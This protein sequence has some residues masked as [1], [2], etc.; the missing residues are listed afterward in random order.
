[1]RIADGAVEE[2]VGVGGWESVEKSGADTHRVL[3]ARLTD[4]SLEVGVGAACVGCYS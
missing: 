3:F 1:M 2:M 4:G